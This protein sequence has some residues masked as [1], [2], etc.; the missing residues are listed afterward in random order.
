[1]EVSKRSS[2]STHNARISRPRSEAQRG[3]CMRMFG[4]GS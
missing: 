2:S 1:M 3:G 4:G